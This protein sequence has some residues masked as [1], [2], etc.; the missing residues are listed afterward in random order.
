MNAKKKTLSF[1]L[2]CLVIIMT[3][4]AAIPAFAVNSIDPISCK[5]QDGDSYDSLSSAIAA[6]SDNDV[7]ILEES[8]DYDK[9]YNT[10]GQYNIMFNDTYMPAKTIT[11]KAETPVD[12][13]IVNGGIVVTK[14]CTINF[15]NINF[16]QDNTEVTGNTQVMYSPRNASC[17]VTF[18]NCSFTFDGDVGASGTIRKGYFD[19]LTNSD[20][21]VL[22]MN[23]CV[24]NCNETT[25]VNPIFSCYN[26]AKAIRINLN[27][28]TVNVKNDNT[29][30]FRLYTKMT[31][32]IFGNTT[33]NYVGGE[34]PVAATNIFVQN[35][36]AANRQ[37]GTVNVFNGMTYGVYA[38]PVLADG[39]A[40]RTVDP[41]GL[42]FTAKRTNENAVCGFLLARWNVD[43]TDKTFDTVASYENQAIDTFSDDGT[44][45]LSLVGIP[46]N[47]QK[48][49]VRAYAEYTAWSV[50]NNDTPVE[51]KITVYS[52]FDAEN[53]VRS[54]NQVADLIVEE[55]KAHTTADEVYKY[56]VGENMYSRYTKSQY[57]YIVTNYATKEN[58]AP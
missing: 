44:Y 18:T 28:V 4:S 16:I 10:S 36:S 26:D 48:F 58:T 27:D 41:S 55:A 37:G 57:D 23:N 43:V 5:I 31:V 40:I 49:A 35:S 56:E 14:A 33:F 25:A 12:L 3:F 30:I 54:I 51:A 13:R 9:E 46:D 1:A 22:S 15:E 38:A 11:I 21:G 17:N 20:G 6:A 19:H 39:A 2:A 29:P 32:N 8:G 42:R 7:I 50:N 47:T 24:I 34:T 53:N 52:A 45:M